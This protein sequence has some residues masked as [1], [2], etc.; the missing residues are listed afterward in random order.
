MVRVA[1]CS[2]ALAGLIV[3]GS[4]IVGGMSITRLAASGDRGPSAV[5]LHHDFPGA[6]LGDDVGH[7][8]QQFY[9]MAREPMHPAEVSKSLDRPQ[10]R[11]QRILFPLAIWALH[12]TGGGAGLIVAMV[13]V[14]LAAM[15]LGA[16]AVGS[17]SVDRG[18]PAWLGALIPLSPGGLITLSYG[19]ADVAALSL[20]LTAILMAE[21]RRY[22]WAAVAAVA[23][24]LTRES[25]VLLLVGWVLGAFIAHG[26]DRRK[27]AVTMGVAPIVALVGWFGIVHLVVPASGRQVVELGMPLVGWFDSARMWVQGYEVGAGLMS[28]VAFVAAGVAIKRIGVRSPWA[29]VIATQFAFLSVLQ[30]GVIGDIKNG[31]RAVLPL[32]VISA[33]AVVTAASNRNGAASTSDPV[34]RIGNTVAV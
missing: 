25:A 1:L 24:V 6:D 30:F 18:G 21:R 22:R 33:I 28:L 34:D 7:D 4:V 31:P 10:Y 11:W 20:A 26:V 32:L 29:A 17:L 13:I 16:W 12:P 14:G 23:A 5:L 2:T 27:I 15:F 8:G 19:L 9:A 3:I